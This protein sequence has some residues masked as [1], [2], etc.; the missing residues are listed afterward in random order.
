MRIAD[1]TLDVVCRIWID[2]TVT[3]AHSDKQWAEANF[4]GF[5][6]H[7]LEACCDDTAGEPL[8]WMRLTGQQQR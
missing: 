3:D 7:P 2:A 8:V 6:H 5:G 1:K 4:K